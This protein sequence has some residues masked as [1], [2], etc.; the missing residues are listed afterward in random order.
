[1]HTDYFSLCESVILSVLCHEE[2]YLNICR[3]V[4]GILNFVIHCIYIYIYIYIYT[5]IIKKGSRFLFVWALL[6]IVHTWKNSP[7]WGNLLR[8]QYTCFTVPTTS[9]RPPWKS[10][11]VSV[12]MTSSQLLL[13]PQLS[14]NDSLWAKGIT[15]SHRD[16]GL[17]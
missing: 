13:S 17:D 2:I 14:H 5:R 6:L 8:L 9:R 4:R 16:Q 7:L 1:M 10:S 3:N 11:C 12:P 15:N